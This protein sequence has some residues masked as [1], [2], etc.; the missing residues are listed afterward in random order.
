MELK[1]RN[2]K[3]ETHSLPFV[4]LDVANEW[5]LYSNILANHIDDS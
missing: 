4:A 5:K 3:L 1:T 2:S